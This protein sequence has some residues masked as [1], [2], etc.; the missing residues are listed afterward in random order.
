MTA[1]HSLQKFV[2]D[3]LLKFE[4][5]IPW[6]PQFRG[7]SLPV[8]PLQL[9]LAKMNGGMTRTSSFIEQYHMTVGTAIHALI[10][11]T[12]CKQEVLWG[13]WRCQDSEHCGLF[14]KDQAISSCPR[15]RGKITYV[16]KVIS[17][18]EVGFSGH[19][20]G[21]VRVDTLGGYVVTEIKSR[22]FN[23]VKQ[24]ENSPPYESDIF[25]VSAYATLAARQ[26]ML[27]IVGRMVLWIGKPRP[28]PFGLWFYPGLGEDL[29]AAQV[30][31]KVFADQKLAAGEPLSVPGK[32][33]VI[34]DAGSCPFSGICFSPRKENLILDIYKEYLENQPSSTT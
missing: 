18:P 4:E 11:A 30:K 8:C 28:S 22:N 13:D 15:C 10:Q 12:W 1:Y 23:I 7:S 20:D 19:C 6:T 2:L 17:D 34:T 29:Y 33:S 16:E 25:Q 14:V 21:V 24:H 9:A 3:S 27:P 26:T 31:L 32:C 5:Q